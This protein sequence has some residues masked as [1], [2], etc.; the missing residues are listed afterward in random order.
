[1]EKWILQRVFYMK[2]LEVP[3]LSLAFLLSWT[4]VRIRRCSFLVQGV[5]AKYLI[6][7]ICSSVLCKAF[8]FALR[9][10]KMR[11]IHF[12]IRCFSFSWFLA[13]SVCFRIADGRSIGT[14]F[15][16]ELMSEASSEWRRWTE[17]CW[18][19]L[20]FKTLETDWRMDNWNYS[21]W[22]E[23]RPYC[24]QAKSREWCFRFYWPLFL[25]S[26]IFNAV[27]LPFLEKM[28]KTPIQDA[29]DSSY[30]CVALS[31]ILKLEYK[32]FGIIVSVTYLS[33]KSRLF[34]WSFR[35]FKCWRNRKTYNSEPIFFIFSL[36]FGTILLYVLYN[37]IWLF[38][39]RL[40]VIT[41]WFCLFCRHVAP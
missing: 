10:A 32:L 2:I 24:N 19:A 17:D 13:F 14:E 18:N 3:L 9:V 36:L 34:N 35:C 37:Q 38:E 40:S 27:G 8:D 21:Y 5:L 16:I 23:H 1:M 26:A 6:P 41:L 39:S 12:M 15:S 11:M 22:I 25:A 20:G 30:C 4:A 28:M 29:Y 7:K 31:F 33:F